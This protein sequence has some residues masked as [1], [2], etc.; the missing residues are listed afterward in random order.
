MHGINEQYEF[1][2]FRE[3]ENS[4]T[5]P[6]SVFSNPTKTGLSRGSFFPSVPFDYGLMVTGL[7]DVMYAAAAIF[8]LLLTG[9]KK[10]QGS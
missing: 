8:G 5:P 7:P 9:R 10:K 3:E 6:A 2:L 1:E 4:S